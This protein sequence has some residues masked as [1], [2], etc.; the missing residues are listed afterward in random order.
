MTNMQLKGPGGTVV[1]CPTCKS[2]DLRYSNTTKPI[3]LLQWM[4]H[5]HALR[6]K[7]CGLRFHERT[8][9]AANSVWV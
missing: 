9:E 7:N 3:D 1:R 6:C 2:D 4:R 5:K 8:D